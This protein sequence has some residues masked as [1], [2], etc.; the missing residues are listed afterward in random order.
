MKLTELEK[1]RASEIESLN[2][3]SNN[4]KETENLTYK[5]KEY[6]S[7]FYKLISAIILGF[8]SAIFFATGLGLSASVSKLVML[9]CAAGTLLC[10]QIPLVIGSKQI[11][12]DKKQLKLNKQNL[13]N[14]YSAQWQE[15]KNNVYKL[16]LQ[17]K[18]IQQ[19]VVKS[20]QTYKPKNLPL[21]GLLSEK[22]REKFNETEHNM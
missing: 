10:A 17:I 16:D 11:I 22:D 8:L 12:K 1:L 6:P 15:T 3:I 4:I 13:L 9:S 2:R 5:I 19:K 20:G 18:N 21:R 7:A 14:Q